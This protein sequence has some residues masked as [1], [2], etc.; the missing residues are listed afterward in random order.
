MFIALNLN[1][2]VPNVLI[3]DNLNN[4]KLKGVQV[5]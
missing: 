3:E 1:K 4:K 2:N 5:V